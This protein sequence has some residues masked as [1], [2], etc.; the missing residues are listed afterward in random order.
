VDN[1]KREGGMNEQELQAIEQRANGAT[2]GPWHWVDGETDK[3]F[4]ADEIGPRGSL[5]TVWE[6]P[7]KYVGGT[8]PEFILDAEDIRR[9]VDATFI[10]HARTD[11]PALVAEVRKLWGIVHSAWEEAYDAGQRSVR[12]TEA[13]PVVWL[14]SKTRA[15]LGGG[16]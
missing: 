9:T 10:A 3:P 4:G 15:A 1:H 8:L 14:S 5:R 16:P 12:E 6:E 2:A 7:A 13:V 11:V